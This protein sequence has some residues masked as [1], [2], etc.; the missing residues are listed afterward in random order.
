[1]PN[2]FYAEWL[3][4]RFTDRSRA[5]AAVGD[6]LEV[7][8]EQGPLWFWSSVAGIVLSL[9]WRRLVAFL[10]AFLCVS[11]LRTF[12]MPVLAPL[13]GIPTA[14]QVPGNWGPFFGTLDKF[15]MLLWIAAP[16]A[17]ICYGF[18]DKLSQLLLFAS[19]ILTTIIFYWWIPAVASLAFALGIGVLIFSVAGAKRRR[20]LFAVGVALAFGF[21][22]VRL[23]SYLHWVSEVY[24]Y[25]YPWT[26]YVTVCLEFLAVAIQTAA[27]GWTHRFVLGGVQRA[28]EIE[29]TA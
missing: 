12:P 14:H 6:L 4:A 15:G 25:T 17:T 2:A 21:V 5:A 23:S 1:M 10:V 13:R 11:L 26:H 18:R 16:Y 7:A 29:S 22:G 27:C 9:T 28:P 19:A 20:A 3:I 24:I 8:A